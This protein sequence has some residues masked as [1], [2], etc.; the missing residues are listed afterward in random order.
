ML[1][2]FIKPTS[3]VQGKKHD[4]ELK[5][6]NHCSVQTSACFFSKPSAVDSVGHDINLCLVFGNY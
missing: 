6:L 5:F 2:L 1:L 3:L 4:F